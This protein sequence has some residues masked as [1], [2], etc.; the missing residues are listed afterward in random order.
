MDTDDDATVDY[1]QY[2]TNNGLASPR[3]PDVVDDGPL[4][5]ADPLGDVS[6]GA[7]GES[8]ELLAKGKEQELLTALFWIVQRTALNKRGNVLGVQIASESNNFYFKNFPR[9]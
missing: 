4:M 9:E 8:A 6:G 7:L 3:H 5:F 1:N 2:A